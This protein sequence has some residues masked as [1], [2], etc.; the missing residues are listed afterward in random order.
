MQC[1]MT[2]CSIGSPARAHHQLACIGRVSERSAVEI[3]SLFLQAS[4]HFQKKSFDPLAHGVRSH[5]TSPIG[6]TCP[7]VDT[8]RHLSSQPSM[9]TMFGPVFSRFGCKSD[10]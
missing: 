9:S 2:S 8:L 4:P 5:T 1:S 6:L 3:P 10:D 7:K